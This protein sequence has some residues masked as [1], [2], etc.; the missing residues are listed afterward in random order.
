[1][2]KIEQI[3]KNYGDFHLNATLEVHAGQIT[4]L[5]GQNGAGKTTIFKTVLGLVRPDA[6]EILFQGKRLRDMAPEDKRQISATLA[7]SGFSN[8]FRIKDISSVLAQMYPDFDREAFA[9]ACRDFQLPAGKRLRDFSRGM[10]A[11]LKL[12]AAL[13][14]GS[15]LL[16][17]DEP[18]AGL[19]V[20][21]RDELL[22]LLRKYME[23]D[24]KRAILV[25]SHISSDLEGLCDDIYMIHQGEMILHEDTDVLLGEYGIIKATPEQYAALDKEYLLR[26]REIPG[27]YQCLTNQRSFYQDNY[28]ALTIEKGSL[29]E[30]ILMMIKGKEG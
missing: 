19:D 14:H 25:S 8:Y 16:V 21:A 18:T 27:G 12:L 3:E 26:T 30:T 5:I 13:S 11:K 20:I 7:D 24:E 17:L 4:G 6:G 28:P 15:R 9:G 23:E 10:Q 2:L 1:M 29:D 22:M